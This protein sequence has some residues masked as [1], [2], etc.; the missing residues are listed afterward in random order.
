MSLFPLPSRVQMAVVLVGLG[1]SLDL[2]AQP[3]TS[4]VAGGFT[5]KF[6]PTEIWMRMRERLDLPEASLLLK[7]P[8]DSVWIVLSS[9]LK[10]LEVPV[11][12][13]DQKHWEMGTVQTKLYR[14]LGKQRL[15]SYLRCGEG[16]TGPNADSYVVYFSF[17][18]FLLSAA[19]GQV[20]LFLLLTGQAVDLAGGRNDPVA[21]T[22]TGRLEMRIADQV[23]ARMLLPP[24]Q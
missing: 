17:D 7:A 9:V 22:S 5:S 21:C 4:G 14:M 23:R 3:P 2:S 19:D 20:S 11:T 13:S 10:A 24:K 15:S 12:F 16:V 6:V 18:G 1:T 8:V